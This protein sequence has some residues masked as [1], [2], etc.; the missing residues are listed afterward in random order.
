M[1]VNTIPG[2]SYALT[3]TAACTIHALLS[4]ASSLVILE[5]ENS[6]QYFFIAPTDTIE[7]SDEHALVTQTFKAAAPGLS[8]RSGI[9]PGVNADL[10]NPTVEKAV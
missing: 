4:D 6:G 7:V 10:K 5:T 2:A 9:R 8:A 1:K 3:C